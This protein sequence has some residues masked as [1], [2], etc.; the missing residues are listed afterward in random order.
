[1]SAIFE[2]RS[3]RSFLPKRV[4]RRGLLAVY[5]LCIGVCFTP[6]QPI[7]EMGMP[8]SVNETLAF[9]PFAIQPLLSMAANQGVFWRPDWALALPVDAFELT[10]D[11]P[12]PR[13]ITVSLDGA[14]YRVAWKPDGSLSAFPTF[15]NNVFTQLTLTA[16]GG[17]VIASTPHC[18][19]TFIG[20]ASSN[21]PPAMAPPMAQI[22]LA[23]GAVYFAALDFAGDLIAETWYDADGAAIALFSSRLAATRTESSVQPEPQVPIT[24]E[25]RIAEARLVDTPAADSAEYNTTHERYDYDSFGNISAIESPRGNFTAVYVQPH[26]PRY[27]QTV[28]GATRWHYTLQWDD[29]G[30]LTRLTGV[31]GPVVVEAGDGL[32]EATVPHTSDTNVEVDLRYDYTFDERG[33]WVERRETRMIRRLGVLVPSAGA[34]VKRNIEYGVGL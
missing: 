30:H 13:S 34:T 22:A 21:A 4:V 19:L 31:A 12:C 28:V 23:G 33:N 25:S 27:W 6:A 32:T 8:T 2:S 10:A 17:F 20:A 24:L 15:V 3:V 5:L 9:T 14:E 18:T 26:R 11:S 1:M 29:A 7:T 16:T